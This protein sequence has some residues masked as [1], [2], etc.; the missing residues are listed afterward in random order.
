VKRFLVE[1]FEVHRVHYTISAHDADEA[2]ALAETMD[3]ESASDSLD[4]KVA[5]ARVLEEI[6]GDDSEYCFD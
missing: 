1:A 2:Q 3:F 5:D 6:V 4:C